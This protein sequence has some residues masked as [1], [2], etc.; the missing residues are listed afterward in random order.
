MFST[1]RKVAKLGSSLKTRGLVIKDVSEA[2]GSSLAD[3]I[4]F[5]S[6]TNE[7]NPMEAQAWPKT[8]KYS[9]N[10]RNYLEGS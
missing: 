1:I 7:L 3:E 4:Q 5:F 9:D 2:V 8:G 6:E 10:L